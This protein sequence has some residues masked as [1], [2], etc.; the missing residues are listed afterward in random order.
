MALL[1]ISLIILAIIKKFV[2]KKQL[3]GIIKELRK[4]IRKKG[5]AKMKE[6]LIKKYEKWLNEKSLEKFSSGEI[7]S[8]E[9]A[10]ELVREFLNLTLSIRNIPEDIIFEKSFEEITLYLLELIKENKDEGE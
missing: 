5:A 8:E 9:E 4:Q 1:N 10:W 6:K 7:T 2:I 3:Y